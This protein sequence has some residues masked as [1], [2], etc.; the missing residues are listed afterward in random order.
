MPCW[1]GRVKVELKMVPLG[2]VETGL[3]LRRWK[4]ESIVNSSWRESEGEMVR[5]EKWVE[6]YSESSILKV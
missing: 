1:S 6:V 5:G 3:R 2:V 4:G